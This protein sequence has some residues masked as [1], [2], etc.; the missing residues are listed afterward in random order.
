MCKKTCTVTCTTW[1]Q[2]SFSRLS[3]DNHLDKRELRGG[4]LRNRGPSWQVF[5][6]KKHC[7]LK[8]QGFT[9]LTQTL[10]LLFRKINETNQH[11][12]FWIQIPNRPPPPCTSSTSGT[13]KKCWKRFQPLNSAGNY[14]FLEKY[15]FVGKLFYLFFA[16]WRK[17]GTNSGACRRGRRRRRIRLWSKRRVPTG[18]FLIGK[19]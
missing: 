1:Q 10:K 14:I 18:T 7:F 5:D 4:L 12:F 8:L 11:I 19:K 15:F 6:R 13:A 2:H 9:T 3:Y 17:Y 16:G